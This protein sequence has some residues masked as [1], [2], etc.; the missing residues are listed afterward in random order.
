MMK[1]LIPIFTALLLSFGLHAQDSLSI[2]LLTCSP[3]RDAAS[4]FGHSAVRLTNHRSGQDQ[5][6]NYGTYSFQEPNFLLKFLRGDL[7]YCLSVD[8]FPSFKQTYKREGRGIVEQPLNLTQ[9]QKEQICLFLHD[10]ARE[11][12]RYYRYDFL[13]DNCATR[14]RDIFDTTGF[15][16]TD[17]LTGVTYRDELTRLVGEK[18]WMMFGIDLLL[19]ARTDKEITVKEMAFL[20][21]RLSA[22]LPEYS[23]DSLAHA[24]LA[25]EAVTILEPGQ[26]PGKFHDIISRVTSPFTVFCLLFLFY[27]LFFMKTGHKWKFVN[28]FSTILYLILGIGGILLTLMWFATN[29]VWTEN[30]WNLLW[31]NPLFLIPAF[32]PDGVAKNLSVDLLSGIAVL[33]LIF[34]WLIPQT[35]HPAVTVIILLLLLIALSRRSIYRKY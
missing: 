8:N 3:G 25:G 35:F 30:N 26:S 24:P 27:L 14:I 21:D 19:G 20:P 10:N 16:V 17:T 31:M 2:S 34:S 15:H 6:F 22:I 11:E 12:N 4:A 18:R 33:G 13:Q 28:I 1:R 32:L 7:D 5:V 23:N 9:E 29:H